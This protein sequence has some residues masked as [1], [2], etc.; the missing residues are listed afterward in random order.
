MPWDLEIVRLPIIFQCPCH[1]IRKLRIKNTFSLDKSPYSHQ[2]S[3]S[4]RREISNSITHK[5][6]YIKTNTQPKIINNPF[7]KLILQRTHWKPWILQNIVLLPCPI[8]CQIKGKLIGCMCKI[9]FQ[10]QD[11]FCGIGTIQ[12][13]LPRRYLACTHKLKQLSLCEARY[14]LDASKMLHCASQLML[15]QVHLKR[16]WYKYWTKR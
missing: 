13:G 3:K 8:R 5:M 1:L 12:N 11:A 7:T 10:P 14:R 15:Y 6:A 16:M 4:S 9:L 2:I